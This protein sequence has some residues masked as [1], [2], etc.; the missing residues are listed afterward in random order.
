MRSTP[1]RAHPGLAALA[2]L[3]LSTRMASAQQTTGTVQGTVRDSQGGALAGVELDLTNEATNVR[4]VGLSAADGGYV[5]NS[6]APGRYT[7]RAAL[8]G[9]RP[10]SVKGIRAEVGRSAVID[11][12]L[13]I[14]AVVETVEV[15][16]PAALVDTLSAQVSTNVE[17]RL[18]EEL[19]ALN[20]SVLELAALAPGVDVDFGPTA[21]GSGQVLNIEGTNAQVNGNRS[22][23]NG[24]YLDGAD[25][26]GA[27]RNQGLNFPNPDAVE[28]LQ[29]ATSNTS[30]E[31]GRQPGGSFNVVTKS[32]TNEVKGT[33]AYFFRDKALNANTWIRNRA[34]QPPLDDERKTFAATV[35]GPIRRD[36]TFF[37]ASFMAFRDNDAA[38]QAT[39][40]FPTE[41]MKRG[42]FSSVPVQ[43]LDPDT[44]QP[45]AGNQVPSRL[46]DPV[47]VSLLSLL[48]DVASYNDRYLWSF[49]RPTR[50]NEALLKID[51][52]LARGHSL[53][54]SYFT[55]WG[56][57]TRPDA[58]GG[59]PFATNTIPAYGS[60]LNDAQQNTLSLRHDW[61][62][63]SHAL[64]ETRVNMSR[65]DANRRTDTPEKSLADFGARNWPINQDGARKY[66][67]QVQIASGPVARYGN[68]SRFD[69]GSYQAGSSLTWTTRAH[70]VKLGA[71]VQRDDVRQYDDTDKTVFMFDG[72]YSSGRT[73]APTAEQF[74]YAFADFLMGRTV[75]FSMSGILDY[76]VHNWNTFFYV[77][78]Q[79]RVHPRLT[80][81]PGLR[82]EFYSPPHEAKDDKLVAFV[83]GHQSDRFPAAPVGLAFAGDTGIGDRFFKPDKDNFAP[84]LGLAYDVFGDG[85]TAIRAGAGIY[86][87]YNPSQIYIWLAENNPWRPQVLAGEAR[88]A[89]PWLTSTT[90]RYSS[91]PTPLSGR[92]V[93][94]FRWTPPF[95][96]L[97]FSKGFETPRSVQ[98]NVAVERE[99]ARGVSLSAGYVGN[100]GRHFTQILPINFAR[101]QDGA[102]DTAASRDARRP[103][104]NYRD[105]LVVDSTA[106]LWYDS[107]QAAATVRRRRLT[108]RLTYVLAKGFDT[109]SSDPTSQGAQTANP[110]DLD[111]ER[112][113]NQRRHTLRAFFTYELPLLRDRT[114]LLGRLAG[115]WRLS[116]SARVRTGRPLNV[117]LNQDWN[118]DGV[119]GDRPDLVSPIGY[120]RTV[121]PDG[122]VRWFDKSAFALPGR[123]IDHNT[124][125]T[126]PRNAVFGPGDWLV[127]LA[128]LKDF[129]IGGRRSVQVRFEA[130]DLFNHHNLDDGDGSLILAFT[131]PD[132]GRL[133]S[134]RDSRR[135]QLGLKLS[136]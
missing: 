119:S 43:L 94:N 6:V 86:Y 61:I 133:L 134:R 93:A 128:L 73:S 26:S 129:R 67:P 103:I 32:G 90:P 27:F 47:A 85:R 114:N 52:Q 54:A 53:Q 37:F 56:R 33:V 55:T 58:Q 120:P 65:L 125:G 64:L 80:L 9:F 117:V 51:H 29:V 77:Q 22:G 71:E 95:N 110:L 135:V 116:G 82:Y 136:Y 107:L 25:N 50:N 99:L 111:G 41:A 118:F 45:L 39:V 72:R 88:L 60:N 36:R 81:T 42:D 20:R 69:Q 31:F 48:P 1:M 40:R 112:A 28:E 101:W 84:R 100:R 10:S 115:G 12:R 46:L 78:D 122:G 127:D 105:V 98:W 130:Y 19:P 108:A 49:E 16:A 5:F 30:A 124:F 62:V 21:G 132:F 18:I 102:Q 24:F 63:S 68:L 87:S 44:R 131:N 3:A 74:G 14:G 89:D 66:L 70:N 2:V 59:P 8:S 11:V 4:L 123:G 97:G 34:G 106:K 83:S 75:G 104:K 126:V 15:T 13:D 35:G 57:F 76:D 96:A 91:P 23:R 7:L 109:A 38:S 92:D 113:E 79:W 17:R 121:E